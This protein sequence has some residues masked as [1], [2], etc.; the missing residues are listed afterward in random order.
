MKA[1]RTLKGLV[2]LVLA[3]PV[4]AIIVDTVFQCFGALPTNR[5]VSAVRAAQTAVTPQ[6]VLEMFPGQQYYQTAALALAFYGIV[7]LVVVVVFRLIA[8][9]AARVARLRNGKHGKAKLEKEG[10]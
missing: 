7:V 3:V 5:V 1:I 4:L 8:A 2:L 9:V 10:R 6:V